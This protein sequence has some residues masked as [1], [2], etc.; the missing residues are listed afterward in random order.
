V[1]VLYPSQGCL[2][3]LLELSGDEPIVGIAGGIATLRQI[4][5]IACLLQLQIQNA[6]VFVLSLAMH[7]LGLQCRFDRHGLNRPEQFPGNSGVHPRAAK[8]HAS[9]QTHHKVRLVTAIHRS[10]LRIARIGNR[11]PAATS[12]AAQHA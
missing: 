8:G 6:L 1:H 12:S 2:P 5:L 11:Q 3:V 9:W 7:A 10:A 4:G